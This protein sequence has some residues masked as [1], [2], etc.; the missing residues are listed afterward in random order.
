[1]E[2][3]P[4]RNNRLRLI[5]T[6]GHGE[7]RLNP[8][9]P[10]NQHRVERSPCLKKLIHKNHQPP[11]K[12]VD[13]NRQSLAVGIGAEMLQIV[14]VRPGTRNHDSGQCRL[15]QFDIMHVGAAGDER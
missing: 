6:D 2:T 8:A 4:P 5:R 14:F 12:T 3:S 10:A 15:Q 11:Q 9:P 1:M 7:R 13:T